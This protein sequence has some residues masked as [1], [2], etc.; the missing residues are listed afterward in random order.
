MKLVTTICCLLFIA[1]MAH[2][3]DVFPDKDLKDLQ[4][5]E[6]KDGKALLRHP[7]GAQAEVAAGD[8][9][10]KERGTVVEVEKTYITVELGNTRMTLPPPFQFGK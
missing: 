6:I 3:K 8:G 7:D 5:V 2:A 4:V 1:T 9:I 10:G